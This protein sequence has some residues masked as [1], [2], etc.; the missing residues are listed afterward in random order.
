MA[1]VVVTWF[2]PLRWPHQMPWPLVAAGIVTALAGVALLVWSR[3]ALGSAFTAFPEPKP[4][5]AAV[6]SGPYRY[7][8][9]PMYGGLLMVFAGVSISRSVPG[10]VLTAAL[11]V[12]WWRKSLE[13][14]RRLTRAYPGYADYRRRT[15]RRFI[16]LSWP[17]GDA[18]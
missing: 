2:R 7:A 6:A 10:L 5:A 12:L 8:R 16:P 14:E 13:E 9:H 18:A 11:A 4:G 3:A 17:R 15:P 1:L